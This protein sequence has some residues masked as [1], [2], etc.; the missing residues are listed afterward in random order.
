MARS[1]R[2]V[3]FEI[4]T[5]YPEKSIEF[6]NKIFGW[7]FEK[8]GTEDYWFAKTGNEN[9]QGIDGALMKKRDPKQPIVNPID[10]ADLDKTSEEI[11]K[12]GGKIVVPKSPVPNMG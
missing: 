5:D 1:N 2:V 11:E 6:F 7:E 12:A 8:F 3:H 10:V 9:E 4:P